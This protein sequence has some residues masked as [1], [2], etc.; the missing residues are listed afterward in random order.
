[1]NIWKLKQGYF[2]LQLQVLTVYIN[3]VKYTRITAVEAQ[4][5]HPGLSVVY[6]LICTRVAVPL[7]SSV[8]A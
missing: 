1:M 3:I 5:Q 8:W 2:D 4:L 7:H 6:F